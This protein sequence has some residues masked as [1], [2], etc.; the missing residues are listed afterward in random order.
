MLTNILAQLNR[1]RT[2][3]QVLLNKTKEELGWSEKNERDLVDYLNDADK[4]T[5]FVSLALRDA[6][7][8]PERLKIELNAGGAHVSRPTCFFLK[9][10]REI[11]ALVRPGQF[12]S[13]IYADC[14]TRGP[15]DLVRHVAKVTY[16]FERHCFVSMANKIKGNNSALYRDSTSCLCDVTELK[17]LMLSHLLSL[18]MFLIESKALSDALLIKPTLVFEP[19]SRVEEDEDQIE[20]LESI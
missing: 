16:Y 19:S 13:A 14:I 1:I 5:I 6:S 15:T 9:V 20:L 4:T 12:D 8:S 11:G 7:S 2:Q 18:R 17:H 3:C 10:D